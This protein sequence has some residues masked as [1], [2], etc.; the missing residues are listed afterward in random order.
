V[1]GNVFDRYRLYGQK[2]KAIGELIRSPSLP[3]RSLL[4]DKQKP[5]RFFWPLGY[6]RVRSDGLIFVGLWFDAFAG[7]PIFCPSDGF[8]EFQNRQRI[9]SIAPDQRFRDDLVL[10]RA[11]EM[12]QKPLA[13]FL[14][15]ESSERTPFRSWPSVQLDRRMAAINSDLK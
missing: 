15:N 2:T 8:H 14:V 4:R 7:A 1:S 6:L 9:L 5:N 12:P 13:S 11:S 10:I 3:I